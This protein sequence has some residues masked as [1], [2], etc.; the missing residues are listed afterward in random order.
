MSSSCQPPASKQ[1]VYLPPNVLKT[2]SDFCAPAHTLHKRMWSRIEV[3]IEHCEEDY[4]I[5][6]A[7]D[8][9]TGRVGREVH[10]RFTVVHTNFKECATCGVTLWNG[11]GTVIR[12]FSGNERPYKSKTHTPRIELMVGGGVSCSDCLCAG[13]CGET[14][15]TVRYRDKK[16]YCSECMP[17]AEGVMCCGPCEMVWPFRLLNNINNINGVCNECITNDLDFYLMEDEEQ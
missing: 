16:R 9:Q 12:T 11:E 10:T 7:K 3:V 15:F 14:F 4:V 6:F 13:G 8:S 5:R 2:V 17:D 1:G